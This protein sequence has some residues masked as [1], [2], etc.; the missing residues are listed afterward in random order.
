MKAFARILL[1]IIIIT[2]VILIMSSC[3]SNEEKIVIPPPEKS[4]VTL[5]I[6]NKKYDLVK[7][8]VDDRS[9]PIWVMYPQDSTVQLPINLNYTQLVGKSSH[10]QT[11]V[12][13]Q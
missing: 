10:N 4:P 2:V 5:V 1:L 9:Y 8:Y 7:V 11:V 3:G 13:L 12:I 6:H